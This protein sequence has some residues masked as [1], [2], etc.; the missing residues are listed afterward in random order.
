MFMGELETEFLDTCENKHWL[1][2]RYIDD[3]YLV[4]QHGENE[5]K[6]CLEKLNS[7]HPIFKFTFQSIN[8][9]VV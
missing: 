2:W 4:W 9:L 5:L 6:D 8:F 3:I 7:L 1:Y